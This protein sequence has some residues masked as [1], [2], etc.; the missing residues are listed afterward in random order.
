MLSC[1]I[2]TWPTSVEQ[3]T[4]TDA[5]YCDEQPRQSMGQA[6][7]SAGPIVYDYDPQGAD[8]TGNYAHYAA[9]TPGTTGYIIDRRGLPHAAAVAAGQVVDVWQVTLGARVRVDVDP[10]N[11][12]GQKLRTQQS[13][14]VTKVWM[15]IPVV[16]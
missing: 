3:S 8:V 7:Y 10:T 1:A 14:S 16:A 9:L 5:R 6:Q 11:T 13:L 2:Y 12:D 15:D 4:N